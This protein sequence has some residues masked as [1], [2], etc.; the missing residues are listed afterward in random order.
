MKDLILGCFHA[1]KI[2]S[3][4]KRAF[5]YTSDSMKE[6]LRNQNIRTTEKRTEDIYTS[7]NNKVLF[8]DHKL[9]TQNGNQIRMVNFHALDL[10]MQWAV[11][12]YNKETNTIDFVVWNEASDTP[13]DVTVIVNNSKIHTFNQVQ[14]FHWSIQSLGSPEDISD[15]TVLINN[16]LKHHIQLNSKNIEEFKL[17]NFIKND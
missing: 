1:A 9:L 10:D 2:S 3:L 6:E 5:N 15:I 4:D 13:C 12:I 7:N 16:K 8:K 11:P 14:K 17:Y